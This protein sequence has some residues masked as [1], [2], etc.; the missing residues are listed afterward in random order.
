MAWPCS[1]APWLTWVWV[2]PEIH[3]E[4]DPHPKAEEFSSVHGRRVSADGASSDLL[5]WSS[6]TLHLQIFMDHIWNQQD[7][8]KTRSA[9]MDLL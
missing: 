2:Q 3:H 9:N 1:G 4:S 6:G 5:T 7:E 8:S